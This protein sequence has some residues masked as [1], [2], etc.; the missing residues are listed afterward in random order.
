MAQDAVIPITTRHGGYQSVLRL[1]LAGRLSM[2]F[3]CVIEEA[4]WYKRA[5]ENKKQKSMASTTNG[6]L[7]HWRNYEMDLTAQSSLRQFIGHLLILLPAILDSSLQ[8]ERPFRKAMDCAVSDFQRRC[9]HDLDW[10]LA[11]IK[12][13]RSDMK[14]KNIECMAFVGSRDAKLEDHLAFLSFFRR[15]LVSFQC[16]TIVRTIPSL[17]FSKPSSMLPP[18]LDSR[19]EKS[20]TKPADDKGNNHKKRSSSSTS[21]GSSSKKSSKKRGD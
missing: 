10:M 19:V 20:G 13:W 3:Q 4:D 16:L 5:D 14:C 12:E 6:V 2:G 17:L 11:I 9:K 18:E 1:T 8:S 7:Q 21:G 15:S